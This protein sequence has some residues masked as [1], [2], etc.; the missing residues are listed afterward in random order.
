MTTTQR[1]ALTAV[2]GM[3]LYNATANKGQIRENGAWASTGQTAGQS[4]ID[5]GSF[6]GASDTSLAVTGQTGIQTSSII[7]VNL[8]PVATA[9]HTADEHLVETLRIEAGNIVAGTGFTIYGVNT[10]KDG[11]S[12][13]GTRI[14]GKWTVNWQ[15]N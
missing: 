3:E 11:P 9:D 2:N 10:A 12:G 13:D 1:D 5:F 14:W 15:W 4:I 8:T 7:E 6:P